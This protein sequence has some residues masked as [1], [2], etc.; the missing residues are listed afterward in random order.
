MIEVLD[1]WAEWCNPC[2][3]SNKNLED[4]KQ[5]H[6][7]LIKKYNVEKDEV[8]NLVEQYSIRALPTFIFLKDGKEVKR[9]TGVMTVDRF[10]SLI[11]TL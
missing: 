4:L 7:D 5:E 3:T 11:E 9:Y 10:E 2:K 8:E 6:K 1:F